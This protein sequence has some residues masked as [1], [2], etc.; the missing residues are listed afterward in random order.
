MAKRRGANEMVRI[1]PCDRRFRAEA[2]LSVGFAANREK[3]ISEG[4]YD[5]GF[6][7]SYR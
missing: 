3:I 7:T 5:H 2:D 1:E 4:A 6:Q